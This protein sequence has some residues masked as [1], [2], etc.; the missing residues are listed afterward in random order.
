MEIQAFLCA[1]IRGIGVA[2]EIFLILLFKLSKATG[3]LDVVKIFIKNYTSDK[4]VL[5]IL[6]GFFLVSFF[7]S[8][9]F[10]NV[11]C[12]RST[13]PSFFRNHSLKCNTSFPNCQ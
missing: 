12:N 10:W 13:N 11:S 3:K 7:E 9:Q 5:I 2:L 4:D 8:I 1:S 6:V